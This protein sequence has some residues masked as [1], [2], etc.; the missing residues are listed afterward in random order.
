MDFTWYLP[1]KTGTTAD[2]RPTMLVWSVLY[3]VPPKLP[4]VSIVVASCYHATRQ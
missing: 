3:P 2:I 1:S 4:N